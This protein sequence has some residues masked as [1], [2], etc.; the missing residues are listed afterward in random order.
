MAFSTG[1]IRGILNSRLRISS[2]PDKPHKTCVPYP[3]DLL[4]AHVN[5]ASRRAAL[6][7][8]LA[9]AGN[10]GKAHPC[11]HVELSVESCR[12]RK[13][14]LPRAFELCKGGLSPEIN[15]VKAIS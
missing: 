15:A 6:K 2:W 14:N 3:V 1:E 11:D 8:V 4:L 5:R 10:H 7:A 12:T 13:T 9:S